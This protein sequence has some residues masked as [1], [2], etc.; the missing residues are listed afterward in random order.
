MYI[1]YGQ[2]RGVLPP[3]F[4]VM[5]PISVVASLTLQSSLGRG[6]GLWVAPDIQ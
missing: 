3:E 1:I 6:V 4:D 5:P 2:Q